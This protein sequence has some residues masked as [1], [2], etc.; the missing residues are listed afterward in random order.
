MPP[1]LLRCA[2]CSRIDPKRVSECVLTIQLL[3]GGGGGPN[4]QQLVG[5][6]EQL[7]LDPSTHTDTLVAR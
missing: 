4:S 1:L 7:L 2:R 6:K 3:R 5:E